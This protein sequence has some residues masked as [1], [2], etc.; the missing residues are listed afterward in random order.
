[1][2][3]KQTQPGNPSKKNNMFSTSSTIKL[4]TWVTPMSWSSTT[5][6]KRYVGVP[7]APY[8]FRG[9]ESAVGTDTLKLTAGSKGKEKLGGW[10]KH[11]PF[12]LD[13]SFLKL[14]SMV[15]FLACS[16]P[17]MSILPGDLPPTAMH[18]VDQWS[19][20]LKMMK[21]STSLL[22][23]SINPMT[24]SCHPQE[25]LSFRK[26]TFL[27]RYIVCIYIISIYIYIYVCRHRLHTYTY[28]YVHASTKKTYYI[29]QLYNTISETQNKKYNNHPTL[30]HSAKLRSELS[31]HHR[32]H[33]SISCSFQLVHP[34]SGV[35][36]RTTGWRP[37]GAGASAGIFR[38]QDWIIFAVST[39][40]TTPLKINMEP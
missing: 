25:S 29:I 28:S 36:M 8:V 5:T 12:T 33:P 1:M 13:S 18:Q 40:S 21:S 27:Y 38:P 23:I 6:A 30:S 31:H 32:H 2:T 4:L 37:G 35:L 16:K 34:S 11:L 10:E 3:S 24:P 20:H 19:E 15:G 26:L 9:K 22:G 14:Y 17:F 39:I 7:S